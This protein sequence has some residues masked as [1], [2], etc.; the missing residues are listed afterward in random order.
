MGEKKMKTIRGNSF[1]IPGQFGLWLCLILLIGLFSYPQSVMACTC[2]YPGPPS[3]EFAEA[4]AVFI[5]QVTRIQDEWNSATPP[6]SQIDLQH[7]GYRVYFAVISS[8]K[9][10][11]TAT[12]EV[13]T[14][15]GGGD[16]GYSFSVGEK[17]VVYAYRKPNGLRASICSR[18]AEL[19]QADEDLQYLNTIPFLFHTD[20]PQSPWFWL[21]TVSLILAVIL[22]VIAAFWL[23]HRRRQAT[24]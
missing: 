15:Y 1:E 14:G 18:T 12:V 20:V 24:I 11:S 8:W 19:S 10:V 2:M 21:G 22:I 3:S 6:S 23:L 9:G 16:C 17:Y 13:T 7:Y 4:D 5:G